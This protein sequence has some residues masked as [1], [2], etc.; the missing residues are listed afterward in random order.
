MANAQAFC[1]SVKEEEERFITLALQISNKGKVI[2]VRQIL[3]DEG[4]AKPAKTSSA[5]EIHLG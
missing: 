2:S 1:R 3:I 5:E 4:F